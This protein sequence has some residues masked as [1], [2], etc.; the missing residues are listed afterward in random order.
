M[1]RGQCVDNA[2][3]SHDH[4]TDG[5]AKGVCFV[6]SLLQQV[7]AGNM[8]RFIDPNDVDV[9]PSQIKEVLMKL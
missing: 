2:P 6:H 7:Q 3:F 9:R 1:I 4:E 5:V 8:K